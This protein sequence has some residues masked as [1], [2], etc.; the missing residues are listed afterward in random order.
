MSDN[1]LH[2]QGVHEQPRGSLGDGCRGG[3]LDEC[4]RGGLAIGGH[5]SAEAKLAR[6]SQ[7]AEATII[8]HCRLGGEG[9]EVRPYGDLAARKEVSQRISNSGL[10]DSEHGFDV[11]KVEADVLDTCTEVLVAARAFLYPTYR[12]ERTAPRS[13]VTAGIQF[14]VRYRARTSQ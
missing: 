6:D 2:G 14:A 8:A 11:K 10:D 7:R 5:G 13:I 3:S 4:N 12:T 9:V 1:Q